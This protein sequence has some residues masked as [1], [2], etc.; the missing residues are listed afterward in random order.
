MLYHVMRFTLGP[1]MRLSYRLW[2]EGKENLPRTG[3]VILASNHLAVIDSFFTPLLA[4]RDVYFLGKSDY[5]T[6]KGLKGAFVRAFMKGVGVIPVDRAGGNAARAAL[7]AGLAVLR[8]GKAFGIY[9]EGT[10]SP[11]GRLYR[12]KTGVARLAL[13][14]GV[15]VVPIAMIDSH[16]AQ[17]IGK[18]LP[19]L[20]SRV[21][22][23]IGSP[24]TFTHLQDKAEDAATLRAVTDEIMTAI[25][26]L[27]AQEY[28]D[29]YAA[30]RKAEIAREERG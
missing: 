25:Q 18:R 14:S 2:V 15:P 23:R 30:T 9:P 29:M 6:G 16:L 13:A 8:E 22:L 19:K 26:A 17:P 10:R 5:F 21:G 27:S 11:D 28:V 7:E 24:L 4:G 12:G 3:P 1:L 20:G